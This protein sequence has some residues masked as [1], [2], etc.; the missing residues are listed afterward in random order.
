MKLKITRPDGTVMEA[1]G[2]KEELEYLST[3]YLHVGHLVPQCTPY[4]SPYAWTIS[5]DTAVGPT[6]SGNI[7]IVR[8]VTN[9]S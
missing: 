1:E 4:N 8:A 7:S 9:E 2:T 3:P 5:S 6:T